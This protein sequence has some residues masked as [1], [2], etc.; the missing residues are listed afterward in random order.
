MLDFKTKDSHNGFVIFF[1]FTLL[2]LIRNAFLQFTVEQLSHGVR[3]NSLA[4][5]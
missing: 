4:A 3:D 2:I 5:R 1:E